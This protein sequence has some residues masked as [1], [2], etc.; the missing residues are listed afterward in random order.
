MLLSAVLFCGYVGVST[1]QSIKQTRPSRSRVRSLRPTSLEDVAPIANNGSSRRNT[2]AGDTATTTSVLA[3]AKRRMLFLPTPD[4]NEQAVSLASEA[5]DQLR[6]VAAAG[7]QPLVVMEPSGSNGQALD[8]ERYEVGGYDAYLQT[9]Y[10]A[11]QKQ[12]IT[13]AQMGMWVIFPEANTPA[14][15]QTDPSTVAANIARTAR[16]QKQYFPSSQTT[17]MFQSQTYDSNDSDW[18][19]GRYV[20]LLPYVQ[21]IPK[22]LIDSFG[23]QGFPWMHPANQG[24]S[25]SITPSGYLRIDFA[26]EAARSL[27]AQSIWFNT[28]TFKTM[29]ASNGAARVTMGTDTRASILD[30]TVDLAS[31]L[32][33]QGFQVFVNIFSEDKSNVGEAVDW[34]YGA[35]S[36]AD[37]QVLA[38]FSQTLASKGI[39]FSQF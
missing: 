28:G 25:D 36:S 3:T 8:F 26:A 15:H 22:G 35:T 13:D 20:S 21:A 39:G 11:L 16:L 29:F 37:G 33:A 5:A 4:S 17:V 32:Q 1:P 10:A 19:D 38:G 9:F 6:S 27:G 30:Q 7:Q 14:W 24:G 34:S 31:T 23:L 12:G 2:N 18:S